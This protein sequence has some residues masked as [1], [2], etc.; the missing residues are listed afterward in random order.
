VLLAASLTH[1]ERVSSGL[2]LGAAGLSL[3]SL[4]SRHG[5]PRAALARYPALIEHWERSSGW[6][7]LWVSLRI[8]VETLER[9][10][11]PEPAA[12]LHGALVASATAPPLIGQ[13]AVRLSAVVDRLA[14]ALG[15]DAL[16]THQ[17][18][19]AGLGD[20]GAVAFALETLRAIGTAD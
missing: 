3:L 13:D 18:R 17:A 12:V 14:R 16:G 5:D 6:N 19:G 15:S 9:A 2:M 1:A 20:K 7:G 4:E 11:H 8:L 10:G